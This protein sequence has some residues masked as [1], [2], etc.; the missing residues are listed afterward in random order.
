M[1]GQLDS[2][3]ELAQR[4]ASKRADLGRKATQQERW[5]KGLRVLS[6]IL[7][8]ISAVSIMSVLAKTTDATTFSILSAILAFASGLLTLILEIYYGEKDIVQMYEGAA[9]FLVIKEE[10]LQIRGRP[11]VTANQLYKDYE[12][13]Q[14][15]YNALSREYDHHIGIKSYMF[16]DPMAPTF[17]L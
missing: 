2:M 11:G 9:K 15:H 12:R 3:R 7:S 16:Y 8:L 10:A 14:D 6:G 5:R 1:S 4:C 17:D 13:L